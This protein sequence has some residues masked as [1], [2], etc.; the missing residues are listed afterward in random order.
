[1]FSIMLNINILNTDLF[2]TKLYH[3]LK[4]LTS[5]TYEFDV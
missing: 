2:K 1:M 4:S 3:L 5:I